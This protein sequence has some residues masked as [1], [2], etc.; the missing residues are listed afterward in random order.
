M[1]MGPMLEASEP[2]AVTELRRP[3][4]SSSWE[5]TEAAGCSSGRLPA[6][7]ACTRCAATI[8]D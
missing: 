7:Q 4:S 6:L 1:S 3:G 8:T 2:W 5:A